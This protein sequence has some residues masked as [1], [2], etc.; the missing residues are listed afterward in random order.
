MVQS[1]LCATMFS[2][3][4]SCD[5]NVMLHYVMQQHPSNYLYIK[6]IREKLSKLEKKSAKVFQILSQ[7]KNK[8][9][10]ANVKSKCVVSQVRLKQIPSNLPSPISPPPLPPSPTPPSSL[11]ISFITTAVT[12]TVYI[13]A[14]MRCRQTD[15]VDKLF[16]IFYIL[17][18]SLFPLLALL[19]TH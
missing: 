15:R 8:T 1:T 6:K 11:L 17:Q 5:G 16:L 4:S 12:N 7:Y 18:R 9:A 2:N 10:G 14:F 13:V 19:F 3:I